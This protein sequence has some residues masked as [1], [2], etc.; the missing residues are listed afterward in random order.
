MSAGNLSSDPTID[1]DV[2]KTPKNTILVRIAVIIGIIYLLLSALECTRYLWW[3]PPQQAAD[4]F[5]KAL[6]KDDPAGIYL[7]S[8]ML[9]A[10]LMGMMVKSNLSSDTRKQMLAKDFNQWKDEFNKGPKAHDTLARERKL[11]NSNMNFENVSCADFKAEVS[12]G[13]I[14]SLESYK[15]VPGQTYHFCYRLSYPSARHAPRVSLLDNIRTAL[16]RRIKSVTIRVEVSARPEVSPP[17]SWI[18]GWKWLD[19]IAPAFPLRYL[20]SSAKAE[21]V[22]MARVSFQIDKTKIDTY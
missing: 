16:K 11:I 5:M 2:V 1:Y 14:R 19:T 4:Q 3:A 22:W 18:L 10:H 17:R 21:E 7:F 20:F 8:D 6:Q 13:E 15:D 12:T 9:G